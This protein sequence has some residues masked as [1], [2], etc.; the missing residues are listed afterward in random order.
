MIKGEKINMENT[1]QIKKAIHTFSE[2]SPSQRKI[3]ELF[4]DIAID[5]VVSASA[6]YI[7][8]K[9]NIKTSTIYFAIN[10]FL[11]DGVIIR[12]AGASKAY[13]LSKEKL[14]YILETYNKKYKIENK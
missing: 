3:L 2:Y 9:T 5:N 11:K 14:E 13:I 7:A 4:I 10:L 6:R 8:E 12:A 1:V